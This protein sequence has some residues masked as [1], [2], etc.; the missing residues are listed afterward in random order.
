MTEE[1]ADNRSVW[2]VKV[3]AGVTGQESKRTRRSR[4]PAFFKTLLQVTGCDSNVHTG[5]T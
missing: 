4:R 5:Q 2:H 3:K 1:M